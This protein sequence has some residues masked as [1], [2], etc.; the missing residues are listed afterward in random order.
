MLFPILREKVERKVFFPFFYIHH[1][2]TAISIDYIMHK[3]CFTWNIYS[4]H[5]ILPYLSNITNLIILLPMSTCLTHTLSF[6]LSPL[7]IVFF[8]NCFPENNW[9][10]SMLQKC[11]PL[12]IDCCEQLEEWKIV[13]MWWNFLS[14]PWKTFSPTLFVYLA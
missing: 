12:C 8:I 6:Y 4:L 1:R 14:F 7:P 13:L 10:F 2:W 3:K 11:S 5:S 9:Q